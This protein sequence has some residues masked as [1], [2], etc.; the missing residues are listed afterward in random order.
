MKHE[1]SC[2][3]SVLEIAYLNDLF[4]QRMNLERLGIGLTLCVHV[5]DMN[6]RAKSLVDL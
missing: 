2:N 5:R 4:I 1:N 3:L 6:R